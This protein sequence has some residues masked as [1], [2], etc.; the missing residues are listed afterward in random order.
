M[1][2]ANTNGRVMEH[3]GTLF[4]PARGPLTERTRDDM[5]MVGLVRRAPNLAEVDDRDGVFFMFE[6][7]RSG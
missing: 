6:F 4:A 5:M 2:R 3:D 1:K 7:V